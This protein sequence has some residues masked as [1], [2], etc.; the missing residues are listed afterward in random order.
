M[1]QT[2]VD[3]LAEQYYYSDGKLTRQDFEQAKEMEKEQKKEQDKNKYNEED[4][5]S[6][7]HFYFKEEFNST[8]QTS[9]STNEV[10]QEW[11]EFKKK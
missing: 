11:K 8:M 4:L 3:W 10:L 2:A 5:I 6:F 9:K 1:K 7:A